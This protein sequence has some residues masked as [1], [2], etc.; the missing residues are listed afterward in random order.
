MKWFNKKSVNGR[1]QYGGLREEC[2]IISL[3]F[4]LKSFFTLIDLM[5]ILRRRKNSRNQNEHYVKPDDNFF[6]S[7]H[8]KPPDRKRFVSP[9]R[10]LKDGSIV[11]RFSRRSANNRKCNTD[12]VN[13][14][15]ISWILMQRYSTKQI[16]S[17][18]EKEAHTPRYATQICLYFEGLPKL[19]V[20]LWTWDDLL[21][22]FTKLQLFALWQLIYMCDILVSCFYLPGI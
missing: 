9:Y 5:G 2:K 13:S 10:L 1:E 3:F 18:Q 19:V 14:T 16:T 8:G 22:M 7:Y 15:N 17:L 11:F 20:N 4:I 6:K 12:R 21:T